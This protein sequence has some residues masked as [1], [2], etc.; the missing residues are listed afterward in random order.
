[1]ASVPGFIEV[2]ASPWGNSLPGADHCRQLDFKLRNTAKALTK[3]SSEKIGSVRLQ[4]AVARVVIL[5]FDTEEE[6]RQLQQ[7]ELELRRK[8]KFRVLG[9]ASLARSIARQR[10]RV[11]YLREGD[12][13]TRFFSPA[14][15]PPGTG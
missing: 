5:R 14:S 6:H 4:L 13:N 8:L 15:M 3:W 9:L 12:A 10:S 11:L 1:M 2:A 7:W